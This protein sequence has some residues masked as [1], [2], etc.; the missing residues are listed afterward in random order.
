V[1][2][3]LAPLGVLSACVV[4][5]CSCGDGG[6]HG[7]GIASQSPTRAIARVESAAGEAA[8]VHVTGSVAGPARDA[9]PV[10]IDMELVRDQGG[11][12][13]VA[14]GGLQAQ[15]E[16]DAG[17]LY[18][19]ANPSL[20]RE[21][22]GSK[23]AA[24]LAG[25]WLKGPADRGP[26]KPL[27]SLTE[28]RTLLAATLSSHR[29]VTSEGSETVSGQ[30]AVGLRDTAT[31]AT[32]YVASTGMPYPLALVKPGPEGGTVRFD[33]WNQAISLEAPPDPLNIK[34]VFTL[35]GL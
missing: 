20:L 16:Q 35:K 1:S 32:L 25:R 2:R 3:V 34:S 5:L 12:G 21:L 11:R 31:G 8:T 33:R 4:L 29:G 24:R 14:V 30:P 17:W 7:N 19:K 26:L 18:V 27:T 28:L 9:S 13:T 6:S 15:L 23:A 22:V 10:A